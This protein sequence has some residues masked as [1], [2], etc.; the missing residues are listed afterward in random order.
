MKPGILKVTE[1]KSKDIEAIGAVLNV[2]VIGENLVF[3]NAAF[4]KSIEVKKLVDSIIKISNTIKVS[5]VGVR[6][7]SETGWLLKST[8]GSYQIII[9][10]T[11][12]DT[13][14]KVFTAMVGLNNIKLYGI[15]WKYD[16]EA[17]KIQLITDAMICAKKKADSMINAIGL[18]IGGVISCSDSY[19]V[20]N[21]NISIHDYSDNCLSEQV[22]RS[23]RVVQNVNLGTEIR[24]R[25][26]ITAVASVEF[27]VNNEIA[28]QGDAPEPDSRRS[29]LS[30]ATSR[31]GDL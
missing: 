14:N 11:E 13:L 6:I 24:G 1:T 3:G 25:K 15:E 5:I 16:E 9:D 28:Q 10:V 21:T 7:E 12:L 23:R 26:R 31:P 22:V 27:Y 18:K 19:E 29:C 2:S 8:K 17:V 30:A 4:E 20:P